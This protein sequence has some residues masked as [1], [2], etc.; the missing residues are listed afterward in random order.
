MFPFKKNNIHDSFSKNIPLASKIT[1]MLSLI[2]L[3][4]PSGLVWS[5]W[6]QEEKGQGL[7]LHNSI[8]LMLS[9]LKFTG[10]CPVLGSRAL[11]RPSALL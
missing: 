8:S 1:R 3:T 7:A 10:S 9:P 5:W 11:V 2:S 4:F 6:S